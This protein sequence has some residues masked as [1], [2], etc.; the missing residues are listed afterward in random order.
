[1]RFFVNSVKHL[2]FDLADLLLMLEKPDERNRIQSPNFRTEIPRQIIDGTD[3][4]KILK[5]CYSS[6]ALY[7]SLI[8]RRT[9][10]MFNIFMTVSTNI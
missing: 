9:V 4:L 7:S 5:R 8:N 6:M 1:M 10:E 3:R 2:E